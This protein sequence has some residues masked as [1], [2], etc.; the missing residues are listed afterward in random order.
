VGC[1]FVTITREEGVVSLERSSS[2]QEGYLLVFRIRIL[3]K[4]LAIESKQ[5]G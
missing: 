5:G 2:D 4:M 1:D 3:M